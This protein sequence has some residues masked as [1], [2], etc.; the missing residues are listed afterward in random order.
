[1][2]SWEECITLYS[3]RVEGWMMSVR[4]SWSMLLFKSS[5]SL[6]IFCLAILPIIEDNSAIVELSISNLSFF[7]S[8]ILGFLLLGASMFLL[9]NVF[10]ICWVFYHYKMSFFI[11]GNVFVLLYILSVSISIQLCYGCYL[12][13]CCM[14]K[15]HKLCCA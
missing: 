1:M 10:L 2:H 4:S 15:Y 11:S 14:I 13:L 5:I 6:L 12:S 7:V 3:S 8:C 9:C